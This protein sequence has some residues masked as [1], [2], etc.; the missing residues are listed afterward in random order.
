MMLLLIDRPVFDL[1]KSAQN[2]DSTSLGILFEDLKASLRS[3]AIYLLG[4]GPQAEDAVSD[5]F[6]IAFTKIGNLIN[7]EAFNS[8]IH[9]ILRNVCRMYLRAENHVSFTDFDGKGL[10]ATFW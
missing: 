6:I 10:V 1:V 3:H 9:A 2:G 4:Y 8:W 5:T 7:P